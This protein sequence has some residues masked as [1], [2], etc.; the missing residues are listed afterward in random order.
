MNKHHYVA[1]MAGGIGSRFW[2]MS[3]TNYPKQFLDILNTG[4]TLIQWTYERFAEFIPKENIF[5]VTSDEYAEI[6][7]TQLPDLPVA[8]ILGEPSRKNTAPCIAYISF[9]LQQMDPQASLIVAP[10]DHL[11]LDT[12]AFRKVCLEALSFVNKHNAF[13]TLGIKPTHPNTG[14]G[15]IQFE[16]HAITDN[17]YKVKTFTEKP[18][19]ELAK[20]F[21]ASGEF[22][23]NAGIFIWQVKNILPAFE[24][25]L[26]EMYE[27]FAAEKEKFNTPEEAE[28]LEA[29]YPQCTNISIDFGIM[30]KA[31]NVYVIPSSFGWSDL[32]TWNSAYEN[33][34]KDYLENAVAGNNVV[35]I[36]ATKC[37]VHVPDDKL[38]L[39]QGLD[40][41]II[42]DTKDVLLIC[43]KNKEQEI[44]EYVNEVKRKKGEK[45]L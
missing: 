9:K 13:I 43:K 18:N 31:D 25:Y 26:P 23:W 22:L 39:L 7:A 30:E 19:L 8:N 24:K 14:Y 3:R 5:V 29:I 20:T 6:V 36:D 28:A 16:Q 41:H 34:E 35:V 37:M 12:I 2:P 15:Y 33:F 42:V 32:G 17:V 4:K 1:I 44:K 21:V 40:D 38:V 11:I 27:V 10:S 45:F